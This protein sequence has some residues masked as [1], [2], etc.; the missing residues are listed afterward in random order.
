M[1]IFLYEITSSYYCLDKKFFHG[2][3]NVGNIEML[4]K[5]ELSLCV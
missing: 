4:N 3:I 1:K 5:L 2:K